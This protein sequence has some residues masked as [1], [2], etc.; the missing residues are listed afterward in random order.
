M[1]DETGYG[2]GEFRTAPSRPGLIFTNTGPRVRNVRFSPV[3]GMAIF[4]GDIILGTEA[5]VGREFVPEG[6][7]ISGDQFRWPGGIV[8]FRIDPGLPDPERVHEA[9]AHWEARTNI[10]FRERRSEQNFVTF[11][12]G[13]GCSANVGMRG[14]EQFVILGSNCTTGNTIHEIG[15]TVGLWHEQSREDRDRFVTIDFTNI[16]ADT[17][18]N[19][20][21]HITDGDDVGDYDYGSIMHYPANAFAIDRTRPTILTANGEPIGQRDGLSEGDIAAVNA[22]YP[23]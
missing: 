2:G 16:Q 9:L 22:I 3:E 12:A 8:V 13:G 11:R 5:E 18:H 23:G 20:N 21:Q 6:V 1:T 10:R 19:F 7:V 4:E 15:H 17:I 14:G